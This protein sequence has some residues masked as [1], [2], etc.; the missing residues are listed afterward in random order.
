MPKVAVAI[1]TFRR[2]RGLERL[3]TALAQLETSAGVEIVVADNDAAAT[4]APISARR[5]RPLIAGRST[6]II[7]N[8]RG[9]AQARNALVEHVLGHSDA[10][11]VAMLD[12]DEWP[13]VL[14]AG[15]VPARAERDA[16][17]RVAR[18]DPA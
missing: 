1:P 11:F 14:M 18:H 6:S 5:S 4:K 15:R 16:G 10:E 8:E 2:P 17:R 9:I 7:A 12:D 3:L 13:S